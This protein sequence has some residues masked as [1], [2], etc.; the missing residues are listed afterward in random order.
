MDEMSREGK[1]GAFSFV[2][3]CYVISVYMYIYIGR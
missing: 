3:L 1:Y 2:L